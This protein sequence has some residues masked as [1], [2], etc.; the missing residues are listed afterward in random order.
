M[1][2]YAE[3]VAKEKKQIERNRTIGTELVPMACPD[4]HSS[5]RTMSQALFQSNSWNS[6]CI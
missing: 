2:V 4:P 3:L 6:K 5:C 1:K